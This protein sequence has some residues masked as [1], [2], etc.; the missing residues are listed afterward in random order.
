MDKSGEPLRETVLPQ[1]EDTAPVQ[2]EA[3]GAR[4]SNR[5]LS[6]ELLGFWEIGSEN[7]QAHLRRTSVRAGRCGACIRRL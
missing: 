1:G 2:A 4:E 7:R 3:G 6:R 5:W